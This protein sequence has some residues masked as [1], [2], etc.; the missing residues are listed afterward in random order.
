[1]TRLDKVLLAEQ[2]DQG[3]INLQPGEGSSYPVRENRQ[4][5]ISRAKRLERYDL[6]SEVDTGRWVIFGKAEAALKELGE[7]GDIIKTMHRAL[8]DH[9]LAEER[10]VSQY[11]PHGDRLTEPVVGRVLGKGL[12]GDEMGERV[13]LVI[14][15]VD[16]RVHHL[17]FADPGRIE[18]I[19]RGMIVEAAPMVARPRAADL[20]IADMRDEAGIYSPSTHL[21]RARQQIQRIGG[22]PEAFVRS[23]VRRLEALRRAGHVERLD[24]DTWRVPANIGERGMRYDLSRSGAWCPRA[25]DA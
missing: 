6:A 17:E 5:M 11:V 15:G 23:H 9:G 14:D 10:G 13:Y 8:A 25:L 22:D 18:D 2:R 7:R 3:V 4:L 21:Q 24:A 20:N 1:M 12:A 19:Q 16:G